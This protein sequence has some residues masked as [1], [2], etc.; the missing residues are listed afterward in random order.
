MVYKSKKKILDIKVLT[1]ILLTLYSFS[2]TSLYA[3]SSLKY[4]RL[5]SGLDHELKVLNRENAIL[6]SE[7]RI[8]ELEQHNKEVLQEIKSLKEAN[9]NEQ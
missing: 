9:R 4:K 5:L 7:I 8:R 6:P 2:V 3:W 1:I